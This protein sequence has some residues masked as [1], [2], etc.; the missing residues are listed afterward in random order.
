MTTRDNGNTDQNDRACDMGWVFN[1]GVRAQMNLAGTREA[2]VVRQRLDGREGWRKGYWP[3]CE[4]VERQTEGSALIL[5]RE[6]HSRRSEKGV[7]TCVSEGL[8]DG[9]H[10]SRVRRDGTGGNGRCHC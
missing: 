5:L 4:D 2:A 1:H 3:D 8:H 10:G 9:G 7:A 6:A